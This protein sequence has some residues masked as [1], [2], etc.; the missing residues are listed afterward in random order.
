MTRSVPEPGGWGARLRVARLAKKWRQEDFAEKVGVVYE[1]VSA[2]ELNDTP[3]NSDSLGAIAKLGGAFRDLAKERQAEVD[4]SAERT[5]VA[6]LRSLQAEVERLATA[7]ALLA[8]AQPPALRRQL[9]RVL[10]GDPP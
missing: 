10:A 6:H 4:G 5:T 8:N 3:P 9:R 2:W 7:L 1:T